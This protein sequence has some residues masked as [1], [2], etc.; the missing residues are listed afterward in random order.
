[1]ADFHA[2][3]YRLA[4]YVERGNCATRLRISFRASSWS[5]AGKTARRILRGQAGEDILLEHLHRFRGKHA[6]KVMRKDPFSC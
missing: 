4:D 3:A 1:M 6:A 2:T 5:E